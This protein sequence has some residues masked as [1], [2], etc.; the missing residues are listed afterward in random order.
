MENITFIFAKGRKSN[1]EKNLI[2]AREFY[3][4]LTSFDKEKFNVK[5]LELNTQRGLLNSILKLIDIFFQKILSLPFY[6]SQL[7]TLENFK[8]LR[9]SQQIIMVNESVACSALLMLPFLKLFTDA[10]ISVFVMGLY[11]KKLKYTFLKKIHLLTIKLVIKSIDNVFFLG[12]GELEIAKTI[13][14][15]D[16]KLIFFPF[17]IDTEFWSNHKQVV[18]GSKNDIIFVGNDGSRDVDLLK[19]LAKK[20]DNYNFIFVSNIPNLQNINLANVKLY[21][22]KWGDGKITDMELRNLYLNSKISIIPLKETTQPSGQSVALQSMSL[23]LPV[24]IS[25][26]QGFWD[27]ETLLENKDII[28]VDD[29]SVDTWKKTIEQVL[30]DKK[31]YQSVRINS[32][33]K[34]VE[35][36]SIEKFHSKLHS[37]L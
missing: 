23:G 33:M 36:Y 25:R 28:F 14:K 4:G 16:S 17:S 5:I 20:L 2:Q 29:S 19:N 37:Y 8:I 1:Y 13:H 18:T 3:Y 21:S 12:R 10:N 27:P 30:N 26:T 9:K 35:N 22:G 15:N 11:S 34:V 32:K 24:L 7:T 31:L 6:L